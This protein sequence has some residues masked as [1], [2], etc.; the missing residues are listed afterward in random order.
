MSNKTIW[1]ILNGIAGEAGWNED[2]QLSLICEFLSLLA[3]SNES[4]TR[5]FETFLINKLKEEANNDNEN[6]SE[7]G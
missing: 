1:N 2:T 6:D 5:Q 7:R 4:T 3:N